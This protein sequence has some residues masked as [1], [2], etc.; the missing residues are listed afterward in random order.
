M[1][2]SVLWEQNFQSWIVCLK[3]LNIGLALWG[4][5][6]WRCSFRN[7]WSFSSASAKPPDNE[8]C[9]V[10]YVLGTHKQNLKSLLCVYFHWIN[11]TSWFNALFSYWFKSYHSFWSSNKTSFINASWNHNFYCFFLLN[12]WKCFWRVVSKEMY[13]KSWHWNWFSIYNCA[14]GMQEIKFCV[15]TMS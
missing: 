14:E 12:W 5:I 1:F 7:K 11:K 9:S 15:F 4:K 2:L 10:I 8:I 3:G 6:I 13:Y